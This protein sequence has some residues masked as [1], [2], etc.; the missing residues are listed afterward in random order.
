MVNILPH[1]ERQAMFASSLGLDL[2]K[3]MLVTNSPLKTDVVSERK[4]G[5]QTDFWIAY[6]GGLV[7]SRLPLSVFKA[8]S[9]LPEAIKIKVIGYQPIGHTRY[10]EELKDFCSKQGILQ[11][12]RW[13]GFL[14]ERS[15]MLAECALCDMGL[16]LMPKQ[17]ADVNE[18]HMA[19]ASSKTFEYLACGLPVLVPDL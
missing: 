3:T 12:V 1:P 6:Q 13:I 17:S 14:N 7:P 15:E 19:G 2:D 8:L 9:L 5:A 11:R 16:S 10:G 18:V 4:T